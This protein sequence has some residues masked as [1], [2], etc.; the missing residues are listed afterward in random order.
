M[1][2]CFGFETSK[3]QSINELCFV[4]AK[5][6]VALK[7]PAAVGLLTLHAIVLECSPTPN[8][9]CPRGFNACDSV[10]LAIDA[11]PA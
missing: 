5:S 2:F 7:A 1:N 10:M 9:N 3:T 6:A 11:S 8:T 4:F